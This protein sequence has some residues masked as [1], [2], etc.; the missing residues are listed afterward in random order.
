MPAASADAKAKLNGN[1]SWRYGGQTVTQADS[2]GSPHLGAT[3]CA[4]CALAHCAQ[5]VPAHG[6]RF[7]QCLSR[8]TGGRRSHG[9]VLAH[10][11]RVRLLHHAGRRRGAPWVYPADRRNHGAFSGAG[12]AGSCPAGGNLPRPARLTG[13]CPA[14]WGGCRRHAVPRRPLYRARLAG[15]SAN[16]SFPARAGTQSAGGVAVRLSLRLLYGHAAGRTAQSHR[17]RLAGTAVE[18][19]CRAAGRLAAAGR[20]LCL[21][22]SGRREQ[23]CRDGGTC[24]FGTC[25]PV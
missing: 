24:A 12:R 11:G 9:A 13:V 7:L 1:G 5:S 8:R 6:G 15:G 10:P 20:L 14:V 19:V 2:R 3:L 23:S 21:P 4:E 25:L 16:D 17:R 22:G 18:S